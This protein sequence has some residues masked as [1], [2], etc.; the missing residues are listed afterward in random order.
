MIKYYCFYGTSVH[1]YDIGIV[2]ANGRLCRERVYQATNNH[3][4]IYI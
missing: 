2:G 4:G 1:V 3:K